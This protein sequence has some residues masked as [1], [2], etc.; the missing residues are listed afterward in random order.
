M[1][2]S[3][4]INDRINI[5]KQEMNDCQSAISGMYADTYT[6]SY[7]AQLQRELRNCYKKLKNKNK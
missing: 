7:M 4:T 1:A 2:A 6:Y 5:L 3:I